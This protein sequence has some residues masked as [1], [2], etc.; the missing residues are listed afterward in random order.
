MWSCHRCYCWGRYWMVS[1]GGDGATGW[2]GGEAASWSY[3]GHTNGGRRIL[4]LEIVPPVF[5]FPGSAVALGKNFLRFVSPLT[6]GVEYVVVV[7]D[8]DADDDGRRHYPL[9][10]AA[11]PSVTLPIQAR[12]EEERQRM[13]MQRRQRCW[14]QG[15]VSFGSSWLVFVH[16]SL[17]SSSF[18]CR[19]WMSWLA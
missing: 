13:M 16:H 11:R 12:Y 4:W 2:K 14:R 15:G 6:I 5:V 19:S 9:F 3:N 1:A 18:P 8:D 10:E 7:A 17:S